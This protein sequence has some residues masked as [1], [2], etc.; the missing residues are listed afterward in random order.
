MTTI[1][2]ESTTQ[3]YRMTLVRKPVHLLYGATIRVLGYIHPD[4]FTLDT[5]MRRDLRA[6]S[7]DMMDIVLCLE[8]RLRQRYKVQI[9]LPDEKVE[10]VVTVRDLCNVIVTEIR[11]YHAYAA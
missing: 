2:E 9:F 11:S 1:T 8:R 7:L 5:H 6:D 4:R 3:E 10:R